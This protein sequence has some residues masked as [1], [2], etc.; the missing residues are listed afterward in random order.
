MNQLL[1]LLGRKCPLRERLRNA[2]FANTHGSERLGVS[3]L[4]NLDTWITLPD[5]NTSRPSLRMEAFGWEL[6][7]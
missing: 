2:I 1:R 7:R 4:T 3:L 5:G 6:R